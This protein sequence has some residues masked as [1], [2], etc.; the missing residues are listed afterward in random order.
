MTSAPND[1]RCAAGGGEQQRLAEELERTWPR[2]SE[3][4]SQADLAAPFEDGDDR[5]VGDADAADKQRDG[6]EHDRRRPAR[7]RVEEVPAGHAAAERCKQRRVGRSYAEPAG[8]VGLDVVGTPHTRV[9]RSNAGALLNAGDPADRLRRGVGQRRV[10]S[11]EGLPGG[12]RQEVRAQLIEL[13]N[14]PAREDSDRPSTATMLAM[15]IAMPSAD[16]AARSFR[17]GDPRRTACRGDLVRGGGS[18][19]PRPRVS[20]VIYGFRSSGRLGKRDFD[21]QSATGPSVGVDVAAMRVGDGSDD[22]EAEAARAR[23]R[24]GGDEGVKQLGDEVGAQLRAGAFDLENGAC[25]GSACAGG[26]LAAGVV[27]HQGVLEQVVGQAAQQEWVCA[28][29]SGLGV[30]AQRDVVWALSASAVGGLAHELGKVDVFDGWCRL[31]ARRRR[32]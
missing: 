1:P 14:E 25:A 19:A 7:H 8:L 28:Q 23:L 16:S 13:S 29:G 10:R 24:V 27:V 20:L 17:V 31:R 32:A 6:T 15:P 21:E 12:D 3:R 2:G 9:D 22:C 5:R 30:E 26:R 11:G 4:P 18:V